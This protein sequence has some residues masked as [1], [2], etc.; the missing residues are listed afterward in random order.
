MPFANSEAIED[1]RVYAS[2]ITSPS[3]ISSAFVVAAVDEGIVPGAFF[4][5]P[6]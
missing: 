3:A 1:V 5:F 6:G 2:T 4:T